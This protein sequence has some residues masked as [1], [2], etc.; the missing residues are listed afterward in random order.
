MTVI[1]LH[2][3]PDIVVTKGMRRNESCCSIRRGDEDDPIL[4]M[5]V[6]TDVYGNRVELLICC[7]KQGRPGSVTTAATTMKGEKC[8]KNDKR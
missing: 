7:G 2:D 1:V 4:S 3:P 6:L 8:H 5:L